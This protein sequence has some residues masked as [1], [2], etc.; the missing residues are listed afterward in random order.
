MKEKTIFGAEIFCEKHTNQYKAL[1]IA[2]LINQASI[3]FDR[4]NILYCL[5]KKG[6]KIKKVFFPQHGFFQDK[7]DNMIESE[8]FEKDGIKFIS[9]YGKKFAPSENDL[10]DIDLIIYDIQDVG[11]RI[12][13][14][15]STLFLLLKALNNKETKLIILDR[16]NPLGRKME[17]NIVEKGF[18]SFVGIY[19]IPMLYG[20]T[21]AELALYFIKKEK[22]SIDFTPIKIKNWDGSFFELTGRKWYPTSPNMPFYT[23][24]YIYP[25]TVLLEG[26]NVSEGRGTTRPFEIIGAPFINSEE[27]ANELNRLKLRGVN[28]IPYAFTPT[29]N[30]WSGELCGGVFIVVSAFEKSFPYKTGILILKIIKRLYPDKF[31]WKSP[32]YEYER[33]KLPIDIITGSDKV[34]KFVEND[35]INSI[36]FFMSKNFEEEIKT[37]RLYQPKRKLLFNY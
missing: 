3:V 31:K 26:T 4:E 2:L 20:L 30:K 36:D 16:P 23:T 37:I 22:L 27:I 8:D 5:L 13:T 19:P 1:N 10:E 12:Y 9:L 28:F 11:A 7:Q 15:V 14:F 6:M 17:G 24:S 18:S 29:F 35:N 25:G 34:R 33:E 21:P 32:P